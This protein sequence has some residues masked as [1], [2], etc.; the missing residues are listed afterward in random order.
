MGRSLLDARSVFHWRSLWA[1]RDLLNGRAKIATT[2]NPTT[3][4]RCL[5][6]RSEAGHGIHLSLFALGCRPERWRLLCRSFTRRGFG[7]QALAS[8]FGEVL[9][10]CIEVG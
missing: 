4:N 3:L 6:P 9:F 8:G 2:L 5:N 10:G 1:E 7:G